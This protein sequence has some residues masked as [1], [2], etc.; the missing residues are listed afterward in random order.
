[1]RSDAI[2]Y[3]SFMNAWSG[4]GLRSEPRRSKKILRHMR[5]LLDAVNT[6]VGPN[7]VAYNTALKAWALCGEEGAFQRT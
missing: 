1:M 6:A 3:T 5:D 4:C 7:I 2:S